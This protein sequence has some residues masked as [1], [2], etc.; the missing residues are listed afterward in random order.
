[1]LR[2]ARTAARRAQPGRLAEAAETA[3]RLELGTRHVLLG[4]PAMTR[5]FALLE[6]LAAAELP[7]L[8]TGETGVGKE[9]AAYAV[10]HWSKRGGPFLPVNCA[11]VGPESLVDAELFGYDKG[12]YTG[13]TAAKAGLFESAS[14]G[15]VFLDEV[16]E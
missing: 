11:A 16:G 12:A 6:R 7:V 8:V 2:A 14:A 9:N 10:H 4:D 3:T 1:I 13:A 5:V 15:P